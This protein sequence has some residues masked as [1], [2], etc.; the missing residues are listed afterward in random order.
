MKT[1]H[2][3]AK[4]KGE[5]MYD[6][7]NDI[8]LFKI[9]DRDY[10][11]SIEFDNLTIDIDTEDFITG[12]RIFDASKVLKIPKIA[13]QHIK[14]F[15]FHTQVENKVIQIQLRFGYVLRNRPIV[16]HGQ[17]FIREALKAKIHDSEVVCTVA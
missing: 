5:Y 17:D 14:K 2:L 3:N 8:L 16:T 7:R 9:K 15:E 1:K 4:G 11:K 12:L 10:A 13:L 6:Y